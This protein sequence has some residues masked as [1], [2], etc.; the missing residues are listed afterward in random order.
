MERGPLRTPRNRASNIRTIRSAQPERH[1]G[2]HLLGTRT[3]PSEGY[4]NQID[5]DDDCRNKRTRTG[6]RAVPDPEHQLSDRTS[7]SSGS[8]VEPLDTPKRT[9][10]R[11]LESDAGEPRHTSRKGDLTSY[12][13][14]LQTKGFPS[15]DQ[16][17]DSA[18]VNT[19]MPIRGKDM[20][21]PSF[22]PQE[23]Q[24]DDAATT[25]KHSDVSDVPCL[26]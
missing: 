26:S 13:T 9:Y 10:S 22:S 19:S 21:G 7:S 11:D 6:I 8:S 14:R 5:D 17:L 23:K 25:G 24:K 15:L 1:K 18:H 12:H 20:L 2:N 3:L 16:Y 4:R